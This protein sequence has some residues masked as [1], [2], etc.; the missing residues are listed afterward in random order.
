MQKQNS[1]IKQ[2]EAQIQ[3]KASMFNYIRTGW[4]YRH[5]RWY[6]TMTYFLQKRLLKLRSWEINNAVLLEVWTQN[7]YHLL[8]KNGYFYPH[9]KSSFPIEL[10]WRGVKNRIIT[11]KML[12]VQNPGPPLLQYSQ[13]IWVRF[14]PLAPSAERCTNIPY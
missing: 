10:C 7:K 5:K 2:L 4:C 1:E 6:C 14:S 12:I 3:Y 11:S 13:C 8:L 9:D